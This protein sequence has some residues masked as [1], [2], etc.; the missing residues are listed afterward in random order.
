MILAPAFLLKILAIIPAL[1]LFMLADYF[2]FDM[3]ISNSLPRAA[4]KTGWLNM[5]FMFP[6]VIASFFTFMN[7]EY[8]VAYA[9]RLGL[10]STAILGGIVLIPVFS[11]ND[12][13]ILILLVYTAYHQVSQQTGI[14]ALIAQSKATT[15][16]LWKW[17]YLTIM[18][19]L[20]FSAALKKSGVISV[21]SAYPYNHAFKAALGLLFIGYAWVCFS[22]ARQSRTRMGTFY[23][24]GSTALI[25][26]NCVLFYFEYYLYMLFL[27]RF[28][29]D[30]TAFSFYVSH[31]VNRNKSK[32]QSL[33]SRIRESL[34]IPEYILT[35]AAALLTAVLLTT[36]V[37]DRYL[38]VILLFLAF[39]HYYWEGVMWKKGSPHRKYIALS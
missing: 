15:H 14:A 30:A 33:S 3:R 2:F 20:V 16:Q 32:P 24:A 1:G 25:A 35:P 7:R 28:I 29:H 27:G 26:V 8:I 6:H 21:L 17:G 19:A 11:T 4:E 38:L 10:S 22:T 13:I 39:F 18:L 12:L 5:L 37:P 9:T 31:N 34:R 36:L 23:I